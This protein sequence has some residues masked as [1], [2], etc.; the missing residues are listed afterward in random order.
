[1]LTLTLILPLSLSPPYKP[2][3]YP[4]SQN[5]FDKV[6]LLLC[7]FTGLLGS[8]RR[9]RRNLVDSR[10]EQG[11]APTA[12]DEDE[13]GEGDKG[14]RGEEGEAAGVGVDML[15]SRISPAARTAA[16]TAFGVAHRL[17]DHMR[18]GWVSLLLVI[19]AMRDLH[20]LPKQVREVPCVR[21]GVAWC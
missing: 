16:L 10:E 18:E 4:T 6:L 11:D 7:R 20:L 5:A 1:M 19:F 13:E 12:E 14:G 21:Y 17:G 3:T 9:R 15:G 2:S 8:S